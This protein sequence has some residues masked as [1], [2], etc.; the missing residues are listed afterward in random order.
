MKQRKDN[1]F[2]IISFFS[3]DFSLMKIHL[4]YLIFQFF[5]GFSLNCFISFECNS[6]NK[7]LL[8]FLKIKLFNVIFL[9]KR[10]KFKKRRK[11]VFEKMI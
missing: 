7:R 1:L 5:K 6:A 11:I 3:P 9:K 4:V 8:S 2:D 10:I